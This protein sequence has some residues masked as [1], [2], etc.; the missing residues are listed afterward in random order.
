VVQAAGDQLAEA[1][2]RWR[3]ETFRV[4]VVKVAALSAA[5]AWIVSAVGSECVSSAVNCT[6]ALVMRAPRGINTV[7]NRSPMVCALA[8]VT[9]SRSV[10]AKLT[11]PVADSSASSAPAAIRTSADGPADGSE[12]MEAGALNGDALPSSSL[13]R[14]AYSYVVAG[15][16]VVSA[17]L[18]PALTVASGV[19]SRNV[20]YAVTATSSVAGCQE[21]WI[22]PTLGAAAVSPVGAVGAVELEIGAVSATRSRG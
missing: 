2:V 12:V 4:A 20:S 3:E 16:T 22:S 1:V 8:S 17:W 18:V 11:V 10:L 15:A 5:C 9:S 21:R 7:A 13:A 14:I 19:P 6:A